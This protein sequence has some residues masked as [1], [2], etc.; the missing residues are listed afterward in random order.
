LATEH[1][2]LKPSPRNPGIAF[3]DQIE[4]DGLQFPPLGSNDRKIRFGSK[5]LPSTGLTPGEL[6]TKKHHPVAYWKWR[7]V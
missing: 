4:E 5:I 2:A 6:Q 7:F 1:L 3:P